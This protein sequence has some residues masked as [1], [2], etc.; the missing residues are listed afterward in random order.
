MLTSFELS[1]PGRSKSALFHKYA[2]NLT[3][4][5]F[6]KGRFGVGICGATLITSPEL[7]LTNWTGLSP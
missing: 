7:G 6:F 3:G 1:K 2:K 4:S 5:A